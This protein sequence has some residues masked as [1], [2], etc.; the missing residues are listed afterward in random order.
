MTETSSAFKIFLEA[1]SNI[2][3]VQREDRLRM[4]ATDR[5]QAQ[6]CLGSHSIWTLLRP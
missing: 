2:C 5:H 4:W 6:V 3:Y 1:F